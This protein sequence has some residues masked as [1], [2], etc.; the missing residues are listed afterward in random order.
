MKTVFD[1][2]TILE[3]L[4]R[5]NSLDENSK[6]QWGKMNV[7]Q[8][9][10]H[11]N[12]WNQWV[13]G[14]DNKVPY[15]QGLLG[16]FIGKMML[17]NNTKDDRPFAKNIPAGKDFT[18]RESVGDFEKQKSRWIELTEKYGSFNNPDFIHG[19]FGKMTKDQIGIFVY[20]H[21]DHHLRQFG[22]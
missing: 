1:P 10:N 11:F 20:K 16:K 21:Y 18:I 4:Q 7:N 5:I 19:L 3:L 6:A 13:L 22:V 8:M 14:I 15:K 17:I 2:V 9:M 12:R